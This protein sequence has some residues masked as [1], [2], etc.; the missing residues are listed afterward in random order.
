MGRIPKI[1][2][3]V[4]WFREKIEMNYKILNLHSR[5][6]RI[7]VF[8]LLLVL[9]ACANFE[10]HETKNVT[11]ARHQQGVDAEI[12]EAELL[13]VGILLFDPGTVIIDDDTVA[14][15]S[16]RQ[17]ESVWFAS[18]LKTALE[19][20]NVWGSVRTMPSA[21]SVMDVI[22]T[23]A[24]IESNGEE[25]HLELTVADAT[26]KTWYTKE[27]QQRASA[28]AY[29]P[30][31][32]YGSDPFA[33]VFAE[34]ANDLF[35]YRTAL[36]SEQSRNIRNVSKVRFAHEFVP[37]AFDGFLLTDETQYSLARIPAA[38]DPMILRIDRLRARNDL[39]LD[40]VQDY[41]RVFNANMAHPYQEWRKTA[42]KEVIYARQLKDQSRKQKVAGVAAIL[43]GILAQTSS[44]NYSRG[45]GHIGIFAG[46]DLIRQGYMKQNEASI[47]S[48]T[49]RELAAALEAEL[50]P[51]VIDL[52]DRSITLS[53]TVEDQFIEW[54]RILRAMFAAENGVTL[55]AYAEPE[56]SEGVQINDSAAQTVSLS[57]EAIADDSDP[58]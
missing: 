50:E 45:A 3:P 21:N 43:A 34:I 20:S 19:Y 18:Q 6:K 53:G 1:Q 32:N 15:A 47:H 2:K 49:L 31:V 30:E 10:Y 27:Y 38:N 16:I 14:S 56:T 33:S 42:Y 24:I 13:D 25:L 17:S 46:A 40:V 22:V 36:S 4:V 39:F 28:Y 12:A 23:G 52:E 41:Y 9:G 5:V 26:G 29:D 7:S 55:D 54:K 57:E 48:S 37:E 8:S 44:N 35:D 11:A 51:S 58:E